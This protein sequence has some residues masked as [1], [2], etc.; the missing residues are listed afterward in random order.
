MAY[1]KAFFT[2]RQAASLASA[3]VVLPFVLDLVRP[4]SIVDFGCG[5]GT[6]L[7]VAKSLGVPHVLGI[8][9]PWIRKASPLLRSDELVVADL[10]V[11]APGLPERF[12]LAISL[13]VA[14]HLAEGRAQSFVEDICRAAPVALFGAAIPEQG[15]IGHVNEQWQS[16]WVAL[17]AA[18]GRRC[19]DLVRPRFWNDR[20]V[21]PWH[22]QNAFLYASDEALKA[23]APW[24]PAEA[25]SSKLMLDL[26]HPD[27]YTL[28]V[29]DPPLRAS[30]RASLRHAGK[31]LRRVFGRWRP[32]QPESPEGV[33]GV[34]GT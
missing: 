23:M 19:L 5:T 30:A 27:V 31:A 26:V 11:A 16:Y 17:F 10:N 7:E 24:L 4:K 32:A 18:R 29:R 2:E 25:T 1:S 9:G 6:W 22:K 8:E 3:R 14:E 13:E 15:G 34:D 21:Q 12:D 28:V 20:E 33:C